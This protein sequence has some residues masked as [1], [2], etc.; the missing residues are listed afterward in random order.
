MEWADRLAATASALDAAA[1]PD[2][3]LPVLE[4]ARTTVARL[5]AVPGEQ[6]RL[7]CAVAV[8]HLDAVGD[9]LRG[10]GPSA[11]APLPPPEQVDAD[12]T[13]VLA[14]VTALTAALTDRLR[15]GLDATVDPAR[16]R[17]LAAAVLRLDEATR[18]LRGDGPQ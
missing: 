15:A 2:A 9:A 11:G 18:A 13:A 14:A 17:T 3:V 5:L 8:V 16:A 12:P 1:G 10:L 6:P 7:G 4:V